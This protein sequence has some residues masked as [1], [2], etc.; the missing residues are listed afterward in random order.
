MPAFI[1]G[2]SPYASWGMSGLY[3]DTFDLFVED[4][5]VEGSY[6]D[7]ESASYKPIETVEETIKVRF[8]NDV[9]LK[10]KVTRNGIII[11]TDFIDGAAGQLVPFL[12]QEALTSLP[13]DKKYSLAWIADPLVLK[14]MGG[15]AK[16][17]HSNLA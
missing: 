7:A 2:R 6:F 13:P 10:Q 14:K 3:P 1:Y 5:S 9:T 11:G 17:G 12:T 16:V 8:G 15:G 4:V